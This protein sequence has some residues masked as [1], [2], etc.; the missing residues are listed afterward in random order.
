MIDLML[1][2]P[3]NIIIPK[4]SPET[5]E[6]IG[7]DTCMILQLSSS[8]LIKMSSSSPRSS[9]HSLNRGLFRLSREVQS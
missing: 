2:S 8:K 4:A 6:P 9:P 1:V 5:P 7:T 3:M